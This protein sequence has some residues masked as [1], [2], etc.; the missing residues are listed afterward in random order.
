MPRTSVRQ[1]SSSAS[2]E[3]VNTESQGLLG[4]SV[5]IAG[6]DR[7]AARRAHMRAQTTARQAADVQYRQPL[8]V[9]RSA[10]QATRS[11]AMRVRAAERSAALAAIASEHQAWLH[12][13]GARP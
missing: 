3:G 11:A 9:L 13:Q 10:D 8:G 4:D 5:V 2:Q 12:A 7:Q 1:A 6:V